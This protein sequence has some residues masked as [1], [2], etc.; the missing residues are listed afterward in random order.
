MAEERV[1]TGQAGRIT[2]ANQLPKDFF[3]GA[4]LCAHQ[5]EGGDFASDWWRWEQRSGRIAEGAT[6]EVAADHFNRVA[7]DMALARKIGMN[8]LMVSL[9]WARVQP[10]RGLFDNAALAHYARV[11]QTMTGEGITPVGVLFEHAAPDWFTSAGGWSA[12][13]SVA[14]F[15]DYAQRVAEHAGGACSWWI[16]LMEPAYWLEKTGRLGQWP[17]LKPGRGVCRRAMDNLVAA[18]H[19][20][21]TALKNAGAS[22]SVGLSTRA[23]AFEPHDP[24]SPWDLKTARREQD[25]LN[26]QYLNRVLAVKEGAAPD[27]LSMTWGGA[28]LV[29]FSPLAVRRGFARIVDGTARDAAPDLLPVTSSGFDEALMSFQPFGLP[30]LA[31]LPCPALDDAARCVL[32]RDHLSVLLSRLGPEPSASVRGVFFRSLLDGFEWEHGFTRRSGLVHVN[33]ADQARTPN[34]SAWLARDFAA[35]GELK[36]G[37][38]RRWCPVDGDKE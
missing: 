17:G 36:A 18:H 28:G 26:N 31:V 30:V 11:F 25:R 4:T 12:P 16:P 34:N 21:A 8:A 14:L 22:A 3:T 38:L 5:V 9:S 2:L 24:G 6:S 33:W 37:V 29:R 27:F 10:E 1:K 20:A 7:A 23:F 19:A 35:H 32:L 13:D 15:R